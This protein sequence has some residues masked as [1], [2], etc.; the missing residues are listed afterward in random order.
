MSKKIHR[1]LANEI[2]RNLMLI[3][4]KSQKADKTIAESL[5][6]NPKWGS[7]D[8]S[9]IAHHTYSVIRWWRLL[10]FCAELDERVVTDESGYWKLLGAWLVTEGFKLPEWP[11]FSALNSESVHKKKQEALQIRK[12]RESVPDWL[13]ELGEIEVPDWD[14][15]LH[16]MNQEADVFIRVNTLKTSA[17]D[18]LKRFEAENTEAVSVAGLPEALQLT[19]R[20]NINSSVSYKKGL[21]EIQDAG[22][23]L[24]TRFI[25]P[26][27]GQK[28]IDGCAGAGGK[29]LTMAQ[30]MEDKGV[31]LATDISP[32][33]LIELQKRAGRSGIEIIDTVALSVFDSDKYLN[34]AD[35]ILLDVPC[36]GSG[37]LKRNPDTKW[38]LKPNFLKEIRETQQHI[39]QKN[40][41][42]L[43]PGGELIY[44]TCSVFRSEN[45]EQIQQFLNKNPEF[46]LD[47]ERRISPSKSGFDG[48]YMARLIKAVSN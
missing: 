11:E 2:I 22:S 26:K 39:L 19:K 35:K 24:I 32:K 40:S 44:A 43:K 36:S 27:A 10:K 12:I 29:S 13:D 42:F 31:I 14:N 46:T 37:V 17:S 34:W 48:F 15:E 16:A 18:L 33:K 30:L 8:R 7:R 23:Q 3:F 20:K 9:F 41:R 25:N 38:K 6:N 4:N 21:F 28:I 5:K 45:E 47:A 1:P